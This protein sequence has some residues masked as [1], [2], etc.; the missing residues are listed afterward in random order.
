MEE[1]IR[2]YRPAVAV[3]YEESAAQDLR[4]RVRDLPVRVLA[5]MEG[6]CELA[7]AEDADT[8][9]NAVVG[10]V[11]LRPTLAAIAARERGGPGQQGN[12][13]S[14]GRFGDSP[15]CGDVRPGRASA[16]GG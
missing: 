3:M 6:L 12:A 14:R 13:G 2:R 7:A 9:L 16:A 1:Q 10:M 5:G 4:G 11:G 15:C 8:V